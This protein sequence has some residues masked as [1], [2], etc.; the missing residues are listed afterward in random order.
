MAEF[1][2]PGV[3]HIP[4]CAQLRARPCPAH[5]SMHGESPSEHWWSGWPGAYCV[6]CGDDDSSEVCMAECECPCHADFW[7]E[8]ANVEMADP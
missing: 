1:V 5:R 7:R 4:T 8:W 6:K 3:E 2:T